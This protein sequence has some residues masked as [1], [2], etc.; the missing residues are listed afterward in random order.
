MIPLLLVLA[1]SAEANEYAASGVVRKIFALDGT[2]YGA[3]TSHILIDGFSSAGS[4]PTNDGLVVLA[5]RDGEG[6]RRQL[7]VAISTKLAGASIAVRVDDNAKNPM[8]HCY[9]R[10]TEWNQ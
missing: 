10:Y 3:D 6:G 2:A 1:A 8:G 5:L 7:A 4:C 9:L